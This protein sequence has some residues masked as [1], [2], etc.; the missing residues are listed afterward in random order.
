MK[1]KTY[2]TLEAA[3]TFAREILGLRN[4]DA[5]D[6][7]AAAWESVG[8]GKKIATITHKGKGFKLSWDPQF[9]NR[10]PKMI[11]L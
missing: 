5:S 2:S 8:G 6:D 10:R 7:Y 3:V 9:E 1:T 11:G 4:W